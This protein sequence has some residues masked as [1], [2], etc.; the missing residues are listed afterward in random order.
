MRRSFRHGFV[1][2]AA[3]LGVVGC[4]GGDT[5]SQTMFEVYAPQYLRNSPLPQ[6]ANSGTFAVCIGIVGASSDEAYQ[7]ELTRTKDAITAGIGEWTAP[8]QGQAGWTATSVTVN[9]VE[10]RNGPMEPDFATCRTFNGYVAIPSGADCD[11]APC[12]SSFALLSKQAVYIHPD[13]Y[14]NPTYT[15]RLPYVVRHELGHLLGMAD[16][17]ASDRSGD[18]RPGQPT[19]TMSVHNSPLTSDD[20]AGVKA[21]WGMLSQRSSSKPVCPAGYKPEFNKTDDNH[22][23][24]E[25]VLACIPESA[26]TQSK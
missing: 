10:S 21:L 26:A 19:S 20:I 17:Y 11:K 6:I 22:D 2:A 16:T 1:F 3:L 18:V 25:R 12:K 9:V 24:D 5:P 8:L 4:R 23:N 7:A 15:P 13:Y 14:S